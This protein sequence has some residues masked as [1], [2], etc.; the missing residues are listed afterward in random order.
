MLKKRDVAH[1]TFVHN[2]INLSAK[3]A[4]LIRE[5][6]KYGIAAQGRSEY[7]A[8]LSGK[9]LT[10][11]RAIRAKCYDCMG[12]FADGKVDCEQTNCPLYPFM[13]YTL[14]KRVPVGSVQSMPEKISDAPVCLYPPKSGNT[15]IAGG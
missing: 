6:E 5:I 15:E 11:D 2:S 14:T 10:R 4:A 8:H 1:S 9:R 7:I 3:R 13:P 12:Y